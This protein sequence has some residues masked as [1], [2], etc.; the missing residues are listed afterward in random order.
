MFL[1]TAQGISLTLEFKVIMLFL[2]SLQKYFYKA[3]E[4]QTQVYMESSIEAW[5]RGTTRDQHSKVSEIWTPFTHI[6]SFSD[7][8]S[9]R[10]LYMKHAAR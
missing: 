4:V 6:V 10:L 3:P 8:N 5:S 7:V 2:H 9:N 1:Y